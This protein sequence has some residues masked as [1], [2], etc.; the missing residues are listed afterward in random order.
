MTRERNRMK[1]TLSAATAVALLAG[2]LVVLSAPTAA[3]AQTI[4]EASCS[5]DSLVSETLESGSGWQMC[6][7]IDSYRGLVLDKV[8]YQPRDD[9]AP[10]LVLDSIAL[11]QLNVP[12]DTGAT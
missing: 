10:I 6:W 9:A 8:A 12:Y 5:G 2:G 1:R 7:R 11:A 4:T 3:S